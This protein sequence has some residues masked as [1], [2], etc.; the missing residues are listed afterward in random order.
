M[1]GQSH[2]LNKGAD[3]ENT[4]P[5]SAHNQQGDRANA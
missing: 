3:A 2:M 1:I 5:T 4:R